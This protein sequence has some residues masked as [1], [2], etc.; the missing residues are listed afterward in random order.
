MISLGAAKLMGI[1]LES[2]GYGEHSVSYS[3][4]V[5]TVRFR[6]PTIGMF[7]P[8]FGYNMYLQMHNLSDREGK[9]PNKFMLVSS[10]VL[11]VIIT[12]VGDLG[13]R[14]LV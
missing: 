5:L 8:M 13:C 6:D 7:L 14:G 4:P 11:F 2:L 1:L 3:P 10:M 9:R 12:V